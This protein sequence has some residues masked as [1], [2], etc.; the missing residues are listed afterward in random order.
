M[1]GVTLGE[2]DGSRPARLAD[3]AQRAGVSISTAARVLRAETHKVSPDLAARVLTAAEE[4]NYTPNLMARSLRAGSPRLL[5]LMVG[6]MLDP[7]FAAI[8]EN[9][10]VKADTLGL[11]AM[12]ANMR[13]DP[14]RELDL[15]QRFLQHRVSG[16]ILSGGGYDQD[17]HHERLVRAV[18]ALTRSGCHVVSLSERDL[19]VPTFT[20]D[21]DALG[22][23]AAKAMLDQ[24][25]SRAAVIY[26]PLMSEVT[27]TRHGATVAALRSAGCTVTEVFAV[28]SREAGYEAARE[29]FAGQRSEWPTAVVAGSDSLAVGVLTYLN[30]QAISVPDEVSLIGVGNTYAAEAVGLTSI[31]EGLSDRAQAA[32]M[33]LSALIKGDVPR[34]VAHF[35]PQLVVRGSIAAPVEAVTGSPSAR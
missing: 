27:R 22:R 34:S 2:R 8:S 25:H 24:G 13:R 1:L 30:S 16:V 33:H 32:V 18:G 21:N 12:V 19:D 3:V 5:G 15:L 17:T 35:E 4:C 20:V 6:D 31:A 26:A 14:L 10:T 7:Y 23:L 9:V 28:Y 29:V 11:A